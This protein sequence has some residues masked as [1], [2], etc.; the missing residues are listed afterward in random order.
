MSKSVEKTLSVS[1][2]QMKRVSQAQRDTMVENF[3][4]I[5]DGNELLLNQLIEGYDKFHLVVGERFDN[6]KSIK[7]SS[8]EL[9]SKAK[10]V[11]KAIKELNKEIAKSGLLLEKRG[12]EATK[13]I[14]QVAHKVEIMS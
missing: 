11:D 14:P 10:A 6:W 7:D 5:A 9:K 4:Q 12:K 2:K 13:G 3:E 8:P 1:R